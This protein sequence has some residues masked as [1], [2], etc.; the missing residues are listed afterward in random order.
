[1]KYLLIALCLF[2]GLS[3]AAV[4]G[5]GAAAAGIMAAGAA[6]RS[7]AARRAEAARHPSDCDA[8][9]VELFPFDLPSQCTFSSDPF[10]C[11]RI[12][13]LGGRTMIMTRDVGNVRRVYRLRTKYGSD[14]VFLPAADGT[15]NP[16]YVLEEK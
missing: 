3:S 12:R 9:H 15:N 2:P 8:C 6:A 1:M 11:W 14:R 5:G 13:Y 16:H 10:D 7:D 4:V